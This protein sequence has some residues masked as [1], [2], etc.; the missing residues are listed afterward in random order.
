MNVRWY[1][2][3]RA[4]AALMAPLVL[5]HLALIFYA[6]GRGLTAAE[7]LGRTRGSLAW[8]AFYA[9]FVLAA[10]VHAA[11]GLHGVFSDWTPL[12]GRRLDVAMVAFCLML[13]ALGLRAV[14]AV[15]LP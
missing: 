7:I 3:Q 15:T 10:S 12:R 1:L 11:I 8:A 14:A 6:S 9:T 13:A 2:L 4:S 5:V